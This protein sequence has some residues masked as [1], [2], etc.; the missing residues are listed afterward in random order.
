MTIH[1]HLHIL[2]SNQSPYHHEILVDTSIRLAVCILF[3]GL[4]C[5][6][7]CKMKMT[8]MAS[9]Q[10]WGENDMRQRVSTTPD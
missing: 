8:T 1:H 3:S 5:F 7:I 9:S 6:P 2:S 4:I 10:D